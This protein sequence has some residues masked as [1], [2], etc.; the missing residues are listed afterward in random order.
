MK[1]VFCGESHSVCR[2]LS[3]TVIVAGVFGILALPSG[4]KAQSVDWGRIESACSRQSSDFDAAVSGTDYYV[5]TTNYGKVNSGRTNF[6]SVKDWLSKESLPLNGGKQK[7]LELDVQE[8]RKSVAEVKESGPYGPIGARFDRTFWLQ[9]IC[10]NEAF[11]SEASRVQSSQ[12]ASRQSAPQGA[13]AQVQNGERDINQSI[14]L[15]QQNQAQGDEQAR[16]KGRREHRPDLDAKECLQL[17]PNTRLIRNACSYQ[18]EVSYCAHNPKQANNDNSDVTWAFSCTEGKGRF[19]ASSL[20]PGKDL[21]G[22][23]PH[24]AD[25]GIFVA[26]CREVYPKDIKFTVNQIDYRCRPI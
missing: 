7:E 17:N 18:I 8:M 25:G 15:A 13:G 4:V 26:A 24:R 12:N 20:R 1:G 14:A 6:L 11:L 22:M 5:T 21:G 10:L 23:F 16:K 3:R 9:R 2:V 19:G